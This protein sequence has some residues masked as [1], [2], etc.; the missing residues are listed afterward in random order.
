MIDTALVSRRPL[1]FEDYTDIVRRNIRWIIAPVVA[2]LVVS[3]VVA[4]MIQDTFVSRALIRIV[5]QQISDTLV[6]NASAQDM[7][8]RIN[9]MAQ[10]IVS[11]TTLTNLIQTYGLY[12]TEQKSEPLEDVINKMHLAIVIRPTI[13]VTN[14]Q[15]KGLPAMEVSYKYRDRLLANKVCADL[16]SRFMNAS[17]VDTLDSQVQTNVFLKDE[18]DKAK[19][20]LD[21]LE[22]QLSDYQTKHAGSLPEEMQGNFEQ[23]TAVEQRLNNLSDAATRI[24]EKKMTIESNLRIVKDHLAA[25]RTVAATVPVKSEKA[26]ELDK[27]IA[28][29]ETLV[30]EMKDKYTPENPDLQAAQETLGA[31]RRQRDEANKSAAAPKAPDAENPTQARERIDAQSQIE[32]LENQL[33]TA[34]LEEQRN[35]AEI[36]IANGQLRALQGR[37]ESTPGSI[38]EYSDLIRD[39]DTAK[40]KFLD[41]D[42]R[43][44]KS[45][46]SMDLERRKQG[47]TLELIDAPS[48]PTNPTEPNRALIIPLGAVGGL[49]VG[50]ILVAIREVK[51]TSLKNLKDARVYT[52][53]SILG[54]IPLLENDVVV[55]RRKQV[56]LVSWAMATVLAIA[57]IVGSVA[58]YYLNRA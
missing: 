8:D 35:M 28:A 5:P 4:F 12:K 29:Q 38:R 51:D 49:L 1:D 48:L 26:V 46:I 42:A 21:R 9:G 37:L 41:L 33:K 45:T 10:N 7:T 55:Q 43:M 27:Q 44:H 32:A 2:G 3:T 14:L 15:G 24:S 54:S 13:G 50:F 6:Q 25:I 17:S 39:R 20:D 40:Q 36:Q 57:I 19:A 47:E 31:L 11:R 52:Q 58:H 34:N 30:A 22:Q 18:T 16:V 23:M 53:L 56:M